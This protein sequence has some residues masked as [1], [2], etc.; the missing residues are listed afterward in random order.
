MSAIVLAERG[1]LLHVV[2]RVH[3]RA[4]GEADAARGDDRPHRVEPEHREPEAA[5]LADDVARPGTRTSSRIE[6]AGVDAAHAHLVVGAA[7][8]RRPATSARR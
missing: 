4:F 6:L 2:D 8:A 7:D 5:D 1:A 3:Q